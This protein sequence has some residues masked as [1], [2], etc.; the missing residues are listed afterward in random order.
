[1]RPM[2]VD[3]SR[4]AVTVD[5]EID[6]LAVT[7]DMDVMFI[8]K[9]MDFGTRSKVISAFVEVSGLDVGALQL[10]LAQ[11]N[12]L[13]WQGPSFG[14]APC[15]AKTIAQLDPEH[16]LLVKALERIAERNP[17]GA[18]PDPKSTPP[19]DPSGPASA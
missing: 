18:R 14:G 5:G 2:F 13:D 7:P 6:P 1:M 8:R 12:I 16:P 3:T 10:A 19:G 17:M 4:V 15:N 11:H 9:R